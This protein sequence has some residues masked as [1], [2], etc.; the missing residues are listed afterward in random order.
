MTSPIMKHQVRA[1]I[2]L[3]NFYRYMWAIRLHLLQPLNALISDKV[4]F[5]WAAVEHKKFNDIKRIV[6]SDNL[7]SYLYFNEKFD[8]HMD[9]NKY[10]L[11]ALINQSDKPIGF[12]IR[13]RNGTHTRYIVMEKE[14]IST[15]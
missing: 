11:G 4:K 12:Y 2:V 13:T 14:L 5:K 9:A 1:F 10:H 8:I 6:A 3:I 7:L 15:V